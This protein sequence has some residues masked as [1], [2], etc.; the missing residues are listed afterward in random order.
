[1]YVVRLPAVLPGTGAVVRPEVGSFVRSDPT[2]KHPAQP[3]AA[4]AF[5]DDDGLQ[6]EVFPRREFQY[7]S[8]HA[9]LLE[10]AL[11]QAQLASL[12]K[13][14]ASGSGIGKYRYHASSPDVA[15]G[16]SGRAVD[17]VI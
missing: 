10:R 14:A 5:V 16:V 1:M 15:T 3:T 6:G 13:S 2:S 11:G 17:V 7:Q 8:T 4:R 9:F 12:P